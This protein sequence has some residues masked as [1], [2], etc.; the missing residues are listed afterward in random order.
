[1]GVKEGW[2]RWCQENRDWL[3]SEFLR[4]VGEEES[5]RRFFGSWYEIKGWSQSGYFLGCELIKRLEQRM[6]L[7]EIALLR[8]WRERMRA[9]MDEMLQHRA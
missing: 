8:N 6:E 1:M 5:V 3:A 4:A 9:E 2:L 7:K